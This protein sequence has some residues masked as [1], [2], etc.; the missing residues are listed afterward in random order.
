[1]L[2]DIV[3]Q[4]HQG[5]SSMWYR[6][7]TLVTIFIGSAMRVRVHPRRTLRALVL[8]VTVPWFFAAAAWLFMLDTPGH[9]WLTISF[10]LGVFSYCSI[11]FTFLMLTITCLDEPLSLSL[12]ESARA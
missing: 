4:Y 2:G 10:N 1:M 11:G 9:S 8:G 7:Q 3:E 5:R 6:R 12:A